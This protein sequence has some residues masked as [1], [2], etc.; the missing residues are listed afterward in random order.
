MQAKL[1]E[2]LR[3][4]GPGGVAMR[5]V[6]IAIKKTDTLSTC[7]IYALVLVDRHGPPWSSSSSTVFVE[8]AG[9]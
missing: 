2:L 4:H 5:D 1:D 3:S 6:S 7:G 9:Q 8:L